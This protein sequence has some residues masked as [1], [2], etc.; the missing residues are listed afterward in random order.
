MAAANLPLVSQSAGTYTFNVYQNQY[1]A[2]VTAVSW[3]AGSVQLSVLGP[4][5]S[6]YV[7]VTSVWSANAFVILNLPAGAYELVVTTASGVSFS[8]TPA[9]LANPL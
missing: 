9:G 3:S 1:A 5:G 6:T 7:P 2:V 8:L 4:D